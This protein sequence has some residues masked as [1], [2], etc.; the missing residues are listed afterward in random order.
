MTFMTM[1]PTTKILQM[2]P[3]VVERFVSVIDGGT[4]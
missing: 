4:K 1:E 2:R 3:N